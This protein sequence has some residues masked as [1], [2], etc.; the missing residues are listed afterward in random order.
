MED[1][2]MIGEKLKNGA[3]A[4]TGGIKKLGKRNLV[5]CLSVLIVAVAIC[6]NWALYSGTAMPENNIPTGEETPDGSQSA[7]NENV[8][9]NVASYF[10]S[11]QIS[12]QQA[13][14]EALEVLQL[15]I[16]SDSAIESAKAEAI[17]DVARIADEIAS[18]ANIESLIKAKGFEDCVAV[19]SNGKA[20]VVVKTDSPL[21]QN[22]VVQIMEIVY[23]QANIA[24]ENIKITE[25]Y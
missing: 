16:D 21:M 13:R 18:E 7:G 8:G 23:E 15:V 17:A 11:V 10:A 24:P 25:K 4:I 19:I 1:T 9:E 12:R 6:V 5:I 2:D 22:E 14:D 20:N 3:E